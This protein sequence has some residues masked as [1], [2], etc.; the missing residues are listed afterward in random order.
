MTAEP[1]AWRARPIFNSA[2]QSRED[3]INA[4]YKDIDLTTI[5]QVMAVSTIDDLCAEIMKIALTES[6]RHPKYKAFHARF[7]YNNEG[8]IGRDKELRNFYL[9]DNFKIWTNF[10]ERKA[11]FQQKPDGV[12]QIVRKNADATEEYFNVLYEGDGDAKE[13]SENKLATVADKMH[14]GVEYCRRRNP[15]YPSIGVRSNMCFFQRDYFGKKQLDF[16]L[17][18]LVGKASN[19]LKELEWPENIENIFRGLDETAKALIFTQFF[20]D[21]LHVHVTVSVDILERLIEWTDVEQKHE[22]FYYIGDWTFPVSDNSGSWTE[23]KQMG[24]EVE[25]GVR[26]RATDVFVNGRAWDNARYDATDIN[27]HLNITGDN[28][29]TFQVKDRQPTRQ[30]HC[31]NVDLRD[32]LLECFDALLHD[33][34]N[35]EEIGINACN[36]IE[37]F[38]DKVNSIHSFMADAWRVR[39]ET[40][41]HNSD[42]VSWVLQKVERFSRQKF[43]P[44]FQEWVRQTDRNG[45]SAAGGR[46][47]AQTDLEAVC[48]GIFCGIDAKYLY[49]DLPDIENNERLVMRPWLHMFQ[50][51]NDSAEGLKHLAARNVCMEMTYIFDSIIMQRRM[52]TEGDVDPRY[53]DDSGVASRREIARGEGRLQVLDRLRWNRNQENLH[54]SSKLTTFFNAMTKII[55]LYPERLGIVPRTRTPMFSEKSQSL[56]K[57]IFDSLERTLPPLDST[58]TKY[59]RRY[60][61]PEADMFFRLTRC[62]SLHVLQGMAR[63]DDEQFNKDYKKTLAM[64]PVAAQAEVLTIFRIIRQDYILS[65]YDLE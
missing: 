26:L 49:D 15:N 55:T 42:G 2:P 63:L 6:C 12:F 20:K 13:Q 32:E 59:L 1:V 38:N 54:H 48:R 28:S 44:K 35:E 21:F 17:R 36:G 16:G 65:T 10:H 19:N 53:I 46:P 24:F 64:M 27:R 40:N 58:V 33:L 11:R 50:S 47:R 8:D 22:L 30:L 18:E 52:M 7:E 62:P 61:S 34:K 3:V 43:V 37:D 29:L 56:R 4:I 25:D 31:R 57:S 9:D 41:K 51:N 39:V 5:M 23:E 60:N 45:L 14:D